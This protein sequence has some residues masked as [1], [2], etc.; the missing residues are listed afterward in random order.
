MK[1]YILSHLV[2]RLRVFASLK[3]IS[4]RGE[5]CSIGHRALPPIIFVSH[6]ISDYTSYTTTTTTTTNTTTTT[7]TTTTTIRCL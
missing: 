1:N 4:R 3:L 2:I 7:T 5:R 6:Q